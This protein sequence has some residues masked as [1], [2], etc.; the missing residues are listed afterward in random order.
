MKI[1]VSLIDN[2]QDR[3]IVG[4]IKGFKSEYDSNLL[5]FN[6]GNDFTIGESVFSI[7]AAFSTENLKGNLSIARDGVPFINTLATVKDAFV[8]MLKINANQWL[9]IIVSE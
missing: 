3:E 9:E 5:E 2:N 6:E 4:D 8:L 1:S 7:K